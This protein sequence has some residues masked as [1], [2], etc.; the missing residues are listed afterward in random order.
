M[1]FRVLNINEN[2]C[3]EFK[4]GD[5]KIFLS[6]KYTTIGRIGGKIQK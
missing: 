1:A 5:L 4:L 6:Y 3:G 2:L